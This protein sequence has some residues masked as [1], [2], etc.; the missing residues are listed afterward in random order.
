MTKKRLL[1]VGILGVIV[2]SIA[3][4]VS[5]RGLCLVNLICNRPHDDS[6]ALI[7]F[8]IIPLFVFSLITYKM[9]DSI[10]QVWWRFARIWI[11]ISMLAILASPSNT[12]NWMFPIEKG[13]V[14][15]FSSVLF[16]AISLILIIIW[17]VKEK[18]L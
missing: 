14:A 18:K 6:F 4:L 15:F 8:P 12:H 10:F 2:F 7:L 9:Q 1:N 17:R 13:S 16:V 3:M 5:I 11:P